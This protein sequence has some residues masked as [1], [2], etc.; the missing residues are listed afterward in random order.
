[1]AMWVEIRSLRRP[2]STS[3]T[4]TGRRLSARWRSSMRP[5]VMSTK[6]SIETAMT[7]T[8]VDRWVLKR[9]WSRFE[10]AKDTIA[11][12]L[13]PKRKSLSIEKVLWFGLRR[14]DR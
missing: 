6:H 1:M 3:S 8:E 12:K 4:R 11:P 5:T 7:T 14:F 9:W 13:T 2:E 10:T